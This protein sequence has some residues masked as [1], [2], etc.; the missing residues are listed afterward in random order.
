MDMRDVNRRNKFTLFRIE[1]YSMYNIIQ[2]LLTACIQNTIIVFLYSVLLFFQW[3]LTRKKR[4]QI[5][6]MKRQ[7]LNLPR[8]LRRRSGDPKIHS[9]LADLQHK[10]RIRYNLSEEQVLMRY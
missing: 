2:S 5:R 6:N 8:V 9:L 4:V 7:N 10:S 1:F 3:I